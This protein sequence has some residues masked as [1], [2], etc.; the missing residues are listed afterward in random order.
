LSHYGFDWL[1]KFQRVEWNPTVFMD[2]GGLFATIAR[3]LAEVHISK[4]YEVGEKLSTT[5]RDPQL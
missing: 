2:F 3:V 4:S 5:D 1:S